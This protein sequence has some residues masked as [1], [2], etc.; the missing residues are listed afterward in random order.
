MFRFLGRMTPR[1][2]LVLLVVGLSFYLMFTYRYQKMSMPTD[3][4]PHLYFYSL[5]GEKISM[6]SR[7]GTVFRLRLGTVGD[8]QLR[9]CATDEG[10]ATILVPTNFHQISQ[11]R[12]RFAEQANNCTLM[13]ATREMLERYESILRIRQYPVLFEIGPDL[14]ILRRRGG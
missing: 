4:P 8:E 6:V 9:M 1:A 10:L 2:V 11:V 12:E 13:V 14:R 5:D 7:V 3:I